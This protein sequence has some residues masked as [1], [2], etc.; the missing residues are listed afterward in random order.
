MRSTSTVVRADAGATR[1]ATR[2]KVANEIGERTALG[3]VGLHLRGVQHNRARADDHVV[4][5]HAERAEHHLRGAHELP[6][7]DH[8]G[9]G[10][11]CGRGHL[12]PVEGLAPLI[13]G[14]RRRTERIQVVGEEHR[15][16]LPEPYDAPL[17]GH[18]LEWDDQNTT[19]GRLRGHAARTEQR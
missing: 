4:P 6:D 2:S 13:P 11:R 19:A 18:V 5:V 16:R 10:Q 3:D 1:R 17:A 15:G 9:I 8:G 7:A 14:N 12:K